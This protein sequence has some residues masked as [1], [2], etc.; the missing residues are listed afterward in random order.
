M[1]F[2][3]HFFFGSEDDAFGAGEPQDGVAAVDGF[4]GVFDLE[5]AA[6]WGEDGNGPVIGSRGRKYRQYITSRFESGFACLLVEMQLKTF[7]GKLWSFFF[8]VIISLII[9]VLTIGF[10]WAYTVAE[11]WLANGCITLWI[12]WTAKITAIKV[13]W[14][15]LPQSTVPTS[16]A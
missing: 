2:G 12:Y 11:Q 13:G 4:E 3:F 9:D 6:I 14:I 7:S 15:K 16:G 1:E 5:E 8:G 10:G